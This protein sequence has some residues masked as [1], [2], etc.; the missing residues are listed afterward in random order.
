MKSLIIGF[1]IILA[2]VISCTTPSTHSDPVLP[3][4]TVSILPQTYFVHR[5]TGDK[6]EINVM[7]PPGHNP[8][9][10]EPTFSQMKILSRTKLYFR[11]GHIP[12]ETSF[13]NNLSQ[14]NPDMKII[15]TS[16]GVQLITRGLSPAILSGK[17]QPDYGSSR[18]VD[19]HIWLSPKSVKLIAK[20]IY[21]TLITV[22]PENQNFYHSN[23]LGFQKDIDELN[24]E[25]HS[26]LSDLK[27]KKFMVFHPAWSYFA[28][29]YGLI[30]VAIEIEGKHPK[31][32]DLKQ[33]IDTARREDI[34]V[35]FVQKQF[36]TH[37][38][39]TVIEEIDGKVIQLDPLS[40]DWLINMKHIVT[41]FKNT[42]NL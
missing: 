17:P 16:E 27:R 25:T 11:I 15:D 10:Y 40:A 32:S 9:T 30:Q 34:R 37:S 28:R 39:R 22:D 3:V 5:I 24:M 42:L 26:A 33:I 14:L 29:D 4:I 23:F 41:T 1:A 36:D 38:A 31:M 8:A 2:V 7:I 35:I 20:H 6:W 12:F 19:P 21:D 13:M 18:G